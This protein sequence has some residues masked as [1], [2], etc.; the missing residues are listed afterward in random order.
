MLEK[1]FSSI[2]WLQL[3]LVWLV[4]IVCTLPS[5]FLLFCLQ[6]ICADSCADKLMKANYRVTAE[7]VSRGPVGGGLPRS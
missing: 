5:S 1:T 6:A 7:A 4:F 3:H 2:H